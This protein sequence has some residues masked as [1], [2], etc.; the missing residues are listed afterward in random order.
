[1]APGN[2]AIIAPTEMLG[3]VA[4]ALDAAEAEWGEPERN[5]LSAPITLLDIPDAKG[6]EFD[7]VVVVEPAALGGLRQLYVALTRT[8]N[9]LVIVHAQ[10]LPPSLVTGLSA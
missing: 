10:A 6:L 5:G 8:T 4:S 2:V 1:V 9:R 7:S 3:A